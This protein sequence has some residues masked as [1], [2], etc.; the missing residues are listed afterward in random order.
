MWLSVGNISTRATKLSRDEEHWIT[1][2]L[3]FDDPGSRF[4]RSGPARVNMFNSI[5]Q[6]FPT[7]FLALVCK[8]AT[9]EGFELEI[10][11]RRVVPVQPDPLADLEWLKH[12]PAVKGEIQHQIDA[13]RAVGQHGRG[14][15]W[16][17]TGGGKTEVA[18]GLTR[19]LPCRWLFLVHRQQLMQ[20]TA[21]RYEERTGLRAARI[22]DGLWEDDGV[23][24]FVVATFQTLFADLKRPDGSAQQMLAGF[25]GV[26]FDEAH[27]LPAAS[28]WKVAM[29]T[30]HAYF[31]V[32]L[33]GTPLARADK[34]STLTIAA[35]GSV[36]YRVRPEV[37]ISLGVLSRPKIRFVSVQQPDD[38]GSWAE[39][40]KRNVTESKARNAALL[41][42]TKQA[43]KPALLFVKEVAHGRRLTKAL[44]AAGI[45]V[46][47]IWGEKA[48]EVRAAAIRRLRHGDIDVIV[49][50]VVFQEG[51]DIP[52]VRAV[53]IGTG[54]S[55]AIA[56]IQRVGRGTRRAEGKTEFEVWDVAD[57]G[58]GM[59][60]RHTKKRIRAYT[61]EGYEVEV[62]R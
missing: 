57:R 26:I 12:H 19:Y 62:A 45:R 61:V 37:L 34:R 50:S 27:T 53:I 23:V 13:V 20:Q 55:S 36:I 21:E 10:A 56:A 54:G 41:Q 33:S 30:N 49:C 35:T 7:G 40:Y 47:F 24:P 32:A 46:E 2:Y 31:R 51:V 4:K 3:S 8:A 5:A 60:E 52:E 25:D 28:F 44:E 22:G 14:V 39:V 38:G 18:I 15:L 43:Q 16:I 6:S 11:D 17:P 58:P 1:Q 29:R 9:A 48:T 42:M 59:L